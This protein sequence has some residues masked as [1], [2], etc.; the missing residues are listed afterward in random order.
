MTVSELSEQFQIEKAFSSSEGVTVQISDARIHL[1]GMFGSSGRCSGTILFDCGEPFSNKFV[2]IPVLWHETWDDLIDEYGDF[3]VE[4][5]EPP[6]TITISE[7]SEYPW[8]SEHITPEIRDVETPITAFDKP[9]VLTEIP[10]QGEY[11][12][13]TMSYEKFTKILNHY[14]TVKNQIDAGNTVF[15]INQDG[16]ERTDKPREF[17]VSVDI[18][19]K[20][21]VFM[22]Q[23]PEVI[24]IDGNPTTEFINKVGAGSI[25]G[26]EG[27]E[28]EIVWAREEYNNEY[29]VKDRFFKGF[30]LR[31]IETEKNGRLRLSSLKKL[32]K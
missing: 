10:T 2:R 14:H 19:G 4:H 26:L 21:L 5:G 17:K 15:S 9:A 18:G 13:T 22:L 12:D 28:V 16:V 7:G 30:G 20:P 3:P 11:E 24:D 1:E 25:E 31:A 29:L 6:E 32:I 23:L 27:E 8:A